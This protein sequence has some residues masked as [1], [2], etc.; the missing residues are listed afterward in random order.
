M[1]VDYYDDE[2]RFAKVAKILNDNCD[3][4]IFT[5]DASHEAE[6]SDVL[7][8]IDKYNTKGKFIKYIYRSSAIENGIDLLNDDDILLILG[9]GDE[10]FLT[11]GLGREFYYGDA[12]Y[13]L[14]YIRKR[15]EKEYE[16]E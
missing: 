16:T 15:K 5:E 1:G 14:K 12:Y 11:M 3:I 7:L 6:V 10:D 2:N 9:K 8:R 13:A 4:V